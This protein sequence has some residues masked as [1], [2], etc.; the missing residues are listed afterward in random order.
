MHAQG[1]SDARIAHK[2]GVPT[3]RVREARKAEGPA[4]NRA[5]RTPDE[6]LLNCIE[7][8]VSH[9]QKSVIHSLCTLYVDENRLRKVWI[10]DSPSRPYD[11][12]DGNCNGNLPTYRRNLVFRRAG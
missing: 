11:A 8:N 5:A 3:E 12:K 1:A 7:K 10:A 4:R 6:L 9:L 2:L